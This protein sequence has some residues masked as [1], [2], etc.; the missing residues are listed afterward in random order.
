[1]GWWRLWRDWERDPGERH[2]TLPA[3]QTAQAPRPP[4]HADAYISATGDERHILDLSMEGVV[5]GAHL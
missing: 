5:L 1:M 4:S 3:Q 2:A